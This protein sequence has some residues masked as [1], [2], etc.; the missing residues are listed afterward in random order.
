MRRIKKHDNGN[1]YLL[2]EDGIWVR[3]FT[4]KA[5]PID[6]NSLTNKQEYGML[7]ENEIKNNMLDLAELDTHLVSFESAV[8]VSDGYDFDRKHKLLMDLPSDIAVIAT[9]RALAKW[10]CKCKIDYFVINNPYPECSLQM[11]QRYF[12]KC[13]ASSKTNP[14]FIREYDE[15]GG[16]IYKYSP[17]AEAHFSPTPNRSICVIDDYRN[18]ICAAIGLVY[19][20][21]VKK[22]LL[23]CCDDAF[24]TDRPGAEQL[25][26]G[27]YIYP[28]HRLSHRIIEANLYWYN[29]KQKSKI[30]LGDHSNGP[31]YSEV[32]YITE[33]DIVK[34]FEQGSY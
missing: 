6:I 26:N 11:P 28:Q 15:Q 9:N 22:L 34:F 5:S 24:N 31:E 7:V 19:S 16:L 17:V 18:P 13:V 8:I 30:T 20:L 32:P 10:N 2:T 3:N 4:K 21:S 33:K 25:S 14:D 27:L 1:E 23:Y 29:R 12:P